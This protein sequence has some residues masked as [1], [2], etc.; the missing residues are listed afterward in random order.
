MG[1]GLRG[2]GPERGS[3]PEARHSPPESLHP[4]EGSV[5]ACHPSSPQGG[6]PRPFTDAQER[7]SGCSLMPVPGA[8]SRAVPC[9]PQPHLGAAQLETPSRSPTPL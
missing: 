6:P 2:G 8:S 3:E 1:A 7:L 9:P 5:G 4:E